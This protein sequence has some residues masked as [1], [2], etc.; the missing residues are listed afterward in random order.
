MTQENIDTDKPSSQASFLF[1]YDSP[2]TAQE[3]R[4]IDPFPHDGMRQKNGVSRSRTAPQPGQLRAA[5]KV[6]QKQRRRS[7]QIG[8]MIIIAMVALVGGIGTW[9]F[10]L[11]S[12]QEISR[13]QASQHLRSAILEA[14]ASV[15]QRLPAIQQLA[16]DHRHFADAEAGKDFR[17]AVKAWEDGETDRL[18]RAQSIFGPDF[19]LLLDAPSGANLAIDRCGVLALRSDPAYDR[20]CDGRLKREIAVL[21]A[22]EAAGNKGQPFPLEGSDVIIPGDFTTSLRAVA[23]LL[24]HVSG[25]W[26]AHPAKVGRALPT[27]PV[28]CSDLRR[29]QSAL[30]F[31][32]NLLTDRRETMTKALEAR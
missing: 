8:G 14:T 26:K 20:D 2:D 1:L 9:L 12:E 17:H 29:L 28:A 16:V 7:R 23:A 31:R 3:N 32:I 19:A 18:D 6:R 13:H 24:D 27:S 10:T 5:T 11:H 4:S 21:S 15:A 30:A 25:C 22:R